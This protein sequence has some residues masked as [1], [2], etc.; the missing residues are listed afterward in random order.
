MYGK[1]PFNSDAYYSEAEPEDCKY[2]HDR[3]LNNQ[4]QK[5]IS[6]RCQEQLILKHPGVIVK[7]RIGP[8]HIRAGTGLQ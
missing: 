7:D 4:I 1:N 2:Q 8:L 5:R 6:D 3:H